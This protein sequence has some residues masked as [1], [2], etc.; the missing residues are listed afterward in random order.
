MKRF[1]LLI[2]SI[3]IAFVFSSFL[4]KKDY[5]DEGE[6]FIFFDADMKDCSL[7]MNDV[8]TKIRQCGYKVQGRYFNPEDIDHFIISNPKGLYITDDE[9]HSSLFLLKKSEYFSVKV[10]ITNAYSEKNSISTHEFLATMNR[11]GSNETDI[12][13]KVMK[14]RLDLGIISFQGLTLKVKPL[15]VNG[16]F[17]S[18]ENIQNGNYEFVYRANIYHK[19][20]LVL[21]ENPVLQYMLGKWQQKSFSIIAGGDIMLSRGAKWYIDQYGVTYPFHEIRDEIENHEVAFANL[22]SPI[23]DR[24]KKYSPYKGIYFRADPEVV[25]GLKFSGFDVFSLANNHTLDWGIDSLIDTMNYLKNVG[26]QY[27]GVGFTREEALVPADFTVKGIR[28]AFICYNDVYPLFLT[29]EGISMRTLSLKG[30]NVEEEIKLLKEKYDIIIASVHTGTEYILQPENEKIRKMRGLIDAGVDVV[31]GSHPHVVQGIEVYK[32]CLI[33]YSLGNLIFDQ[34]W[35]KETSL[36][37]LLEIAFLGSR[38]VYYRP[39]VICIEK[40]KAR[41]I[42]ND[43]A[44]YILSY[45]NFEKGMR[46]HVT[47]N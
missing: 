43:E 45:L 40:S 15:S 2:I 7:I 3:L 24:G 33:A 32:D 28:I 1:I 47:K 42:E 20:D 11:V 39:Q 44:K 9:I 36:G 6:V 21:K 35:S 27:S 18:L 30:E 31:I 4:A 38:L 41:I 22:E 17:P 12:S 37:L 5:K 26:L 14:N 25:D 8:K 10:A 16:V 23:S 29:E 19:D 13:K 46:E 34:S